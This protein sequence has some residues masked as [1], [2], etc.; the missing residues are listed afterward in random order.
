MKKTRYLQRHWGKQSI[1]FDILWAIIERV[2]N[3][4]QLTFVDLFGWWWVVSWCASKLFHNVIY[5]EIDTSIVDAFRTLQ[6]DRVIERLKSRWVSREKFY[7]L[8]INNPEESILKTCWSF[9]NNRTGYL[10]WKTIERRKE[11]TH[12][13]INCQLEEEYKNLIKQ[14]NDEKVAH[15]DKYWWE[16]YITI[17]DDDWDIFSKSKNRRIYKF[18][19]K[20]TVKRH[21]IKAI[22]FDLIREDRWNSKHQGDVDLLQSLES[23]QRLESLQ[24]LQS[25]QR[26]EIQ[27]QSYENVQLPKPNECIIYCD[28]PY[29]W[30]EWYGDTFNFEKFDKYILSLKNKW[31]TIFLSEYNFKFGEVIRT[32]I[33]RG[34]TAQKK[35]DYTWKENLYFI[36]ILNETPETSPKSI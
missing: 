17:P 18:W 11:L 32:K 7:E 5:N 10:Y 3:Y 2:P 13:I 34:Y 20:W 31:Y 4:S 28:P 29:R 21:F 25:L 12:K 26:L 33:K 24:S 9:G 36:K 1:V 6:D 30:T 16:R 14:Y 23:L 15:F 22:D 35:W 8:N 27:N 19:K